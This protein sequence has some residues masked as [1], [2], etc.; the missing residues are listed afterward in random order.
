MWGWLGE[1]KRLSD[2]QSAQSHPVGRSNSKLCILSVLNTV[3]PRIGAHALRSALP[4]VSAYTRGL[5]VKQ[6]PPWKP[7][8]SSPSL[9]LIVRIQRKP[10]SI[11]ILFYNFLSLK[12][13]ESAQEKSFY[14]VPVYNNNNNNNN[15]NNCN[16]YNYLYSIYPVLF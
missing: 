4:R 5:H 3:F 11:S 16:N 10:V 8:P 2:K 12:K 7:L 13:V 9:S 6:A 1:K 15:N 14:S